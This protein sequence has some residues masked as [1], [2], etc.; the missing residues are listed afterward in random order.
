[1]EEGVKGGGAARTNGDKSM[2]QLVTVHMRQ[3]HTKRVRIS[4][5]TVTSHVKQSVMILFGPKPDHM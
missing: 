3:K 4:I 1:M 5:G 2:Q